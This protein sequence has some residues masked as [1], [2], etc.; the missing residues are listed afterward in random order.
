M[1]YKIEE[2]DLR[3]I[4]DKIPVIDTQ[5]GKR[6]GKWKYKYPAEIRNKGL[7]KSKLTLTL[8]KNEDKAKKILKKQKEPMIVKLYFKVPNETK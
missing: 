6:T 1:K 4:F 2:V 8:P 5:T 3:G 7:N